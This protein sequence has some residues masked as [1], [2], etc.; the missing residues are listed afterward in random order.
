MQWLTAYKI[1]GHR[2]KKRRLVRSFF[3]VWIF[4]L[5]NS[6]KDKLPRTHPRTLLIVRLDLIGDYVLFR[7]FLITLRNSEFQNYRFTL[8]G[9][10]VFK[11]LAE[12]LD[13][14]VVDEFI[15]IDRTRL[16]KDKAY[17]FAVLKRI[18][19]AGFEVALQPTYSREIYGDLLI[20]ASQAVQ[21]IGVDGDLANQTKDQR[22]LTDAF[23]TRLIKTDPTPKF[24]FYRNKEI[25]EQVVH[26]HVDLE[27]PIIELPNGIHVETPPG[28]YAVVVVGASHRRKQ[29]LHFHRV[30]EHVV[31]RYG[32]SAV[33]V[34]HGKM[35]QRAIRAVL[36]KTVIDD[37]QNLCDKT[38]LPQLA[39]VI[40]RARLVVS[41][42]TAAV[43][44]AAAM[45]TPT[46]CI[47]LGTHASR[48]NN[49]PQ[50]TGAHIKFVFPEKID[51]LIHN[52]GFP[53]YQSIYDGDMDINSI[54]S[55]KV[56]QSIDEVMALEL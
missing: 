19:D 40:N 38:T 56:L 3:L 55:A 7:N 24:E 23:Y 44:F 11:N 32:L 45:S 8:C 36:Q 28:D 41:N 53:D 33:L 12:C 52:G 29:W 9:N 18:H 1:L 46:V 34:G 14:D 30:V 42:D 31:R 48:F 51:E 25:I 54:P 43:H 20:N 26:E 50:E 10:I 22:R 5:K 39:D 17:F 15:W 21:R 16:L 37:V 4:L 35:D 2:F 13:N 49:Y 6:I 47:T 27:R